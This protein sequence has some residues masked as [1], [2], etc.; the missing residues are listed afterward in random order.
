MRYQHR[1]GDEAAIR[2]RLKELASER[3]RFGWRRLKL[4]LD[5]EGCG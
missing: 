1:R 2:T 4:L 5:R 3:R